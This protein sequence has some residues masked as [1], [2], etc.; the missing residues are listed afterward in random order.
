M[1]LGLEIEDKV[2]A[3]AIR[4]QGGELLLVVIKEVLN[5]PEVQKKMYASVRDQ[6]YGNLR[7]AV[8]GILDHQI[9]RLLTKMAMSGRLEEYMKM[10]RIKPSGSLFKPEPAKR[11]SSAKRISAKRKPSSR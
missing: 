10:G 9:E 8:A 6:L 1:I 4:Y 2:I 5:S 11:K 7:N 3:H